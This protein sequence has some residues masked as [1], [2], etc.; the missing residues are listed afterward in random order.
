VGDSS[1]QG[2]GRVFRELAGVGVFPVYAGSVQR[3][4]EGF[5]MACREF[6]ERE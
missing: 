4:G 3:V 5:H 2:V 6:A 1:L